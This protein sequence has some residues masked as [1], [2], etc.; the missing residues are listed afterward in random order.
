M[1]KKKEKKKTQFPSK[2]WKTIQQKNLL[3]MRVQKTQVDLEVA[4]RFNGRKEGFW[5]QNI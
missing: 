4:D 3:K 2:T 1:M 5:K